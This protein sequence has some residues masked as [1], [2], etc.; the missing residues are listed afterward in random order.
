MENQY[1]EQH[2][3]GYWIAGSRVSLESVL[4]AFRQG[5]TPETIAAECFPT[6]TLE[7][8]YGA[9]T[10]Y[11]AYRDEMDTYLLQVKASQQSVREAAHKDDPAFTSTLLRARRQRY[12]PRP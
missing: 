7:Q 6:L 5:L 2:H 4:F 9:I 11:L 1:L 3:E 10:Y 12:T 8:V